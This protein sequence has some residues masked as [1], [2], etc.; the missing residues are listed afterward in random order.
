MATKSVDVDLF[1]AVFRMVELENEDT[2]LLKRLR[3]NAVISEEGVGRITIDFPGTIRITIINDLDTYRLLA[4]EIL[5][6][7]QED[8]TSK[9]SADRIYFYLNR[10][11]D[12]VMYGR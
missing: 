6:C 11:M 10:L 9:L 4:P 12:L 7:N 1:Q 5:Y 2:Y 3:E 8:H